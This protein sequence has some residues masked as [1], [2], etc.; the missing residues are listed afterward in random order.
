MFYYRDG[1]NRRRCGT[2]TNF[3]RRQSFTPLNYQQDVNLDK[4]IRFERI[5]RENTEDIQHL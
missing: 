1:G 5:K 3:R 4:G 2:A